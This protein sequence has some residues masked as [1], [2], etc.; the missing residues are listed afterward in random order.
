MVLHE[1]QQRLGNEGQRLLEN[2]T[3]VIVVAVVNITAIA[4]RATTDGFVGSNDIT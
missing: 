3:I 1:R 2:S 4:M